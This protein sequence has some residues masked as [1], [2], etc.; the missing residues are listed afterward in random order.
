MRRLVI[1]LIVALGLA[2][3]AYA[4]LATGN[5]Y[6]MVADESGAALPGAAV[7][8]KGSGATM[9]TTSGADGRYRFLNLPPG[10][11]TVSVALT[12]FS[13]VIRENVIV[14]T[15]ANID[16]PVSLK[17]AQVEETIT[18]TAESP[19][20]DTKKVGTATNFTQEELLKVPNSRDP[21][22]LL[23][24][25]P[26]MI[27]DRVNIAGNES[28]QQS[29][30]R[31]KGARGADAVWSLDGVN[32]TDMA[33]TGASPT[34]FD[35]DA[36]DEIQISTSGNDIRQPTGGVGL[37]FVT[38]RGTNSFHGTARGY[39]TDDSL[40]WSNVPGELAALGVTEDTADHNDRL[41]DIGF[42]IGG[43]IVKDKLWFWASVAKQD[44]RLIR[45]SGNI[46]D[47]TILK[48]Y[49]AKIN[50]QASQKDNINLLWFWGLK[51]KMGRAPGRASIEA[52]TALWN[53]DDNWPD[54][55]PPGLW[56]IENNHVF[57]PNFFL[58]AKYAYYGTGFKLASTG[59]IDQQ[60]GISAL[61][62]RSFGSTGSTFFL[63]PQHSAN[64]DSNVFSSALGGNH[65]FKF[66][67]GYRWTK[68]R[69]E[70][71]WP[72]DKVVGYE[73]AANDFRARLYRDGLGENVVEYWSA[74]LGDTF[75]KDRLTLNVGV[76]YDRQ[77]GYARASEAS[78]NLAF[79]NVVPGVNFPGYDQPFTWSD[80]SPRAGLT[81]ALDEGRKTLVRAS[82]ARYVGQLAVGDVSYLN[83]A[84][85]VGFAD[86]RWTDANGDH[87]VQ[88]N[89]VI[90]AATPITSGG[91]FN[92]SNPTAVSSP[93]QFDPDYQGPLTNE[94]VA[95]LD[96]ELAPNLAVS[97]SYTYR[98][99]SR[100]DATNRIGF[101]DADY[102]PGP[103]V[104]GTVDGQT[105][106]R[107]TF[108]PNQAKALATGNGRILTNRD[109]YTQSFSGFE[110]ALV[111]RLSS[112]WM[113][114]VAAGYNNHTEDFDGTPR[115]ING[116]LTR[117]DN[118]GAL[119]PGGQVA[120]LTG[121]SGFG[122]V[123]L[124]GKWSV[125]LNTMVQLPWDVELAGNLFG[126]QGTPL[127][128]YRQQALG[129]DGSLRVLL[130]DE[131][132]SNRF[133][134][135]W[136]LDLRLAKNVKAGRANLVFTADM[137]N[138]LN[139]NTE[140]NRIRNQGSTTFF[141]LT[142]NLSPRIVRFGVRLGI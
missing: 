65:E 114:R 70:E 52:P 89:E 59:P 142:Q 78:G 128:I 87:L 103:N 115:N 30:F 28:G 72:G 129:Q 107:P 121:G 27:L 15:G 84:G 53:Q 105:V 139:S 127:A 40:E 108:I 136:N 94:F 41:T 58:S 44:I 77:G 48:D 85:S 23:R 56:K 135:L 140:I 51:Q 86:Y 97:V 102:A 120:P 47:R 126:K 88:P 68:Q 4:Q 8:L 10:S 69:A 32:I 106:S 79:P 93:N 118:N 101:T 18:V 122:D 96:R 111:K 131:L 43:P 110:F 46:T 24:T 91:G 141:R 132:D 50:W 38:K 11:Y 1:T 104:T 36:F 45:Q 76:R 138:V 16:I 112:K 92:P 17:V 57:N 22:A 98:R 90:L 64:I 39:Y 19:V 134:N 26:G 33:A 125:N 82:Y 37:N 73:F 20:I 63:R 100:F 21:W 61:L 13:T 31:A 14:N 71:F 35:Y 55:L 34:Y 66:G 123:L 119:L 74:Y 117:T 124:N 80:I 137:F 6:G 109:G 113:A 2:V 7:S 62:G 133:D 9:S 49:T 130:N 99:L 29:A 95:G 25:V 54:G 67:V 42:D 12:G 60:A 83:T 116:Q 81:Y 75:T 5:I 3:P